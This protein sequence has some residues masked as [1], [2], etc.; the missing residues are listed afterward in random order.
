MTLGPTEHKLVQQKDKEKKTPE[1]MKK[2]NATMKQRIEILDWHHKQG[3]HFKQGKTAEHWNKQYPNL[4]LKQPTI[5]AWLRNEARYQQQYEEELVKGW[6]GTSKRIKQTE[7]PEVDEMLELWIAK[8]MSDGVQL[9]GEIIKQKWT[10]FA[11]IVG[12]SEDEQVSMS[13]GWLDSVKKCCGLKGFKR[14][15]EAGSANSEDVEH[16]H[17]RI[18]KL[19]Q[20]HGYRLKDIF[21]MDDTGL[22]WA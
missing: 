16:E 1:F 3:K 12:V 22:F 14:H 10:C 9:N 19:I 21:N 11:D 7:N 4:C 20:H 8:A 17:E 13:G 2:E 15:G 18:Q 5:S 6:A